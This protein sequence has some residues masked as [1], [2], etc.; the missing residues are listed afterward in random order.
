[1]PYRGVVTHRARRVA[2]GYTFDLAQYAAVE[3]AYHD[4]LRRFD[5]LRAA[6]I[7]DCERRMRC[8][9]LQAL[10]TGCDVSTALQRAM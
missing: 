10:I 8:P 2:S 4:Q 7:I 6:G 1:M 5:P 3:N 9:V